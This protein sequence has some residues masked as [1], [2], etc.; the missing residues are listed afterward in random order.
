[1]IV[2][3]KPILKWLKRE[4]ICLKSSEKTWI[5]RILVFLGPRDD[6]LEF[7]KY[8]Y[9]LSRLKLKNYKQETVFV[10]NLLSECG[11]FI[12][13]VRARFYK[14]L[15]R[16][17]KFVTRLPRLVT[18]D[19]IEIL[20][21]C[22]DYDHAL[23]LA[24]LASCGRRGI[25]VKRINTD[26]VTTLNQKFLVR[27]PRDKANSCPVNFTIAWDY[28]VNLPWNEIDAEWRK[29]ITR[30]NHCPFE[31]IKTEKIRELIRN[32]FGGQAFVL[33][34]LRNRC[35]LRLVRLK[36]TTDEVLSYIGWNSLS[37]FKRYTKLSIHDIREFSSL[38]L[39]IKC[40]NQNQS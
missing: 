34:S 40:I 6:Y 17:V 7:D 26:Q 37:S 39:C 28:S 12:S 22:L 15:D 25:D 21:N 32:K 30:K 14:N 38:D 33:H 16:D 10:L 36:W 19:Q 3:V 24:I 29:M 9:A 8:M 18:S 11:V 13:K 27:I 23:F 2:E 5:K 4:F 1:M 35:A 20:F 31:N